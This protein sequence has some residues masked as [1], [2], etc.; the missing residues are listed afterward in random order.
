MA[1]ILRVMK[2]LSL[3]IANGLELEPEELPWGAL[4]RTSRIL[5]SADEAVGLDELLPAFP[6]I[7]YLNIFAGLKSAAFPTTS[8][9]SVLN[10]SHLVHVFDQLRPC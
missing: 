2:D 5:L 1:P 9:P 3:S 8:S 10:G 7:V 4:E 6:D